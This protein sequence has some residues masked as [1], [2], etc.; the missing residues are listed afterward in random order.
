MTL[1]TLRWPLLLTAALFASCTLRAQLAPSATTATKPDKSSTIPVETK[2]LAETP[3]SV[4]KLTPFEV[5]YSDDRGY[6]ATSTMSGTRLNT[7]LEDLGASLSVVTKQQLLDTASTDIN[8]VFR[9]ELGTES[10]RTFTSFSVDRG[11]VADNVQN[12]PQGATRMRGLTSANTSI[13]GFASN[14]PFDSYNIDSVE[15]SRGPNSTVFGLGNTGG[16]V[17]VI[18]SRANTS[19]DINSFTT[20]GDSYGGY[21]GNFDVNRTLVKGK[22]AVRVM[23]LY[24]E[25]GYE[26]RPSQDTTR[27]LQTSLTARP[28]KNT[29][30]YASF[31][32]YRNFNSRPNTL[33]PRDTATDW[34]ASGKPTW[35]PLTQTVHFGDGRAPITGVT[36]ALEA[37]QLP[38]GLAVTDTGFT[39]SPSLYVDR[40][41][42]AG[43][44]MISR[45]PN[46][47]GTGPTNVSGTGRLLQSG[48]YYI[49]NSTPNPLYNSPQISN[50]GLYDWT[51]INLTAPNFATTKGETSVV[52]LEQVILQTPR[53]SLA[54]QASWVYER[55]TTADRRFLG[56]GANLQPFIDVNE[57]MLDG[58]VNPYFLRT[59][60]GGSAPASHVGRNITEA[61]RA[62]LA[63]ELDLS[64][65][66]NF[67]KWIG[68]HR[69][70]GYGEYREGYGGNLGF[71]DAI[72]SNNSWMGGTPASRN[73]AGYRAY[74]R[75]YVGD[76]NG[77]NV[78]YA[79]ARFTDTPYRQSL[80]FYNGATSQWVNEDV[81]FDDY[82]NGNRLNRRL[83][84]TTG[85]VW[86]GFFLDGRIVPI[87]GIRKDY[88]RTRDG[89][90]AVNPTAATN[91]Y[92]DTSPLGGYGQYDWVQTRGKTTN[93]GIVVKPLKWL[94]LSYNQAN[95]FSP[96]SQTYDVLG[97]P[98]PDPYGKT[99]DYGFQLNLLQGRLRITAKQFETVDIGRSTSDLNT[100]VQRA[101]RM[102]RRTSSGDPGLTDWLQAQ[103]LIAHPDWTDAQLLSEVKTQTGVDPDY[104]RGHINKTH[105]DAS[106]SYSYGKEVEI[107]F[108]PTNYWTVK[109]TISQS[110]P[111]NGTLSPAVQNY[112]NS[113]MPLWT[114]IKDPVSGNNWWTSPEA[115][116]T[117]PRD[118]YI[119]NVVAPLKLA[120][121]LQGKRRTQTREYHAAALT[122]YR[123]AGITDN[124]WLKPLEIGGAVRWENK[125]SIGFLGAAADAD[126]IV[127]EYN[128]NK[129]VYDEA[130]YY[131]DLKLS[132]RFRFA[133]DK[134]SCRVQL[135][136]NDVFENGRLQKV[137]VNPDGKA[138]AFRIV[139]PRQFILS[140]TFDL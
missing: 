21:R 132:Y 135:N 82:Y 33:T 10:A 99:K 7:N 57:T 102:D 12:D 112:I 91:G 64:H 92:Y 32:S 69:F 27:R 89:N 44:L 127:R 54:A 65:E 17:N 38:Y 98:L 68:K 83:L 73:S 47:S 58:S 123:L 103:L 60:V 48:N 120:V 140:A 31:E 37:T 34:I 4:V 20:R 108:N 42:S 49:R 137:A 18:R 79:P 80:R 11:V 52:Q 139:D 86:Q 115:S 28:F 114:T 90:S 85:G 110:N 51:S 14:L 8:D 13:D 15:I 22:L 19:R 74:Q 36:T 109:T 75:Y 70:T 77:Q 128:P 134:M 23:G 9:Y 87:A 71:V 55:I 113:R 84:S 95:S 129:P 30:I 76:A 50:K 66:S 59:Y 53:N 125:A 136:I 126:G 1:P 122:N 56:S 101:I 46:A 104:I 124:R 107:A 78:D 29:S 45:L 133:K 117:I 116:G 6:Q 97:N 105:G 63:Y 131:Y 41:G 111:I 138:W 121:A 25:K 100:I 119:A 88:N 106:N 40:S 67:L 2:P 93:E 118:F 3:E 35:D 24:E 96:G 39:N 72:S 61:Y 94:F 26:R 5:N 43:L 16:G 81:T 130:H 62:T